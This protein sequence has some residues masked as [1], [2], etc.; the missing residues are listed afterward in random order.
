MP[1][2]PRQRSNSGIYHIMLRGANRQEIFHDTEDNARFLETLKKYKNESGIKVYGWCLIGN[3]VHL[4]LQEGKEYLTVTM[5]RIGVSYV[6]FYNLNNSRDKKHRLD[7]HKDKYR[8]TGVS[9]SLI[10]RA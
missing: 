1:R 6:S 9:L 4:L 2:M 10:S 5:K 3:H 8:E 7:K